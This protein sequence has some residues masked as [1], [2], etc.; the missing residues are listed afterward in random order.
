MPA[1]AASPFLSLAI[2]PDAK[3]RLPALTA[4][5]SFAGSKSPFLVRKVLSLGRNQSVTVERFRI[6]LEQSDGLVAGYNFGAVIL[7]HIIERVFMRLAM[8]RGHRIPNDDNFVGQIECIYN[9]V[10]DARLGPG[11]RDIE[12]TDV[13]FAQHSIE[14]R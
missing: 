12:A 5:G 9:R 7:A 4:R 2:W 14:P 1:S 11:A 10:L 8:R 3:T 13:E 6:L